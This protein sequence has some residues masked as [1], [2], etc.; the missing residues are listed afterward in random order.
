LHVL[1]DERMFVTV[2]RYSE[3][4]NLRR[5]LAMLPPNTPA[6]MSREEAMSLITELQG[7]EGRLKRLKDDLQRVISQA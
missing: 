4:E 3:L 1:E 7:A 2:D 6:G 5:S